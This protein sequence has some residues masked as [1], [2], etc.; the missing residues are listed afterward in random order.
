MVDDEWKERGT[1]DCRLL[2]QEKTLKICA[3]HIVMPDCEMEENVSSDRAWIWHAADFAEE[4]VKEETFA[5]K[6]KDAEIAKAFRA[7]WDK[8][9]E[10]NRA[11]L[12]AGAEASGGA[13]G[14]G[15]EAK[16]EEEDTVPEHAS[17]D[18]IYRDDEA[19]L[20]ASTARYAALA[21]AFEAKYGAKPAFFVRAPG[22]VNLIGEHIDYHNYP[23]CPMA[24]TQDIAIAVGAGEAHADA[25]GATVS[26]ANVVEKFA[27]GAFPADP[28]AKVDT[29]SHKWYHY[30]QCGYKGA[31]DAAPATKPVALQLMI[32]GNVPASAGVSSSSALVVASLLATAEAHGIKL[33]RHALADYSVK[34]ERHIGTMSGGMDQTISVFGE[35]GS[36]RL[37]EFNP[38]RVHPVPLP[39]DGVF[40]VANSLVEASKAVDPTAYY[41]LRVTEGKL[42]AK[43]VCKK[44]GAPGWEGMQTMLDLQTALGCSVPGELVEH[45]ERQLKDGAY[46]KEELAAEFGKPC[47]ELFEGDPKREGALNVLS[48]QDGFQLKRR[49]RHVASEAARVQSFCMAAGGGGDDLCAQ[50]GA[51]MDQ[52]QDSCRDDYECSCEALDE[53][54]AIAREGGASGARLTGAGWGGCAVILAPAAKVD[55][56][57]E[58]VRSKFFSSRE[59]TMEARGL[60]MAK[61]LFKSRPAPGAAIY[62]PSA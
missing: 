57:L 42:A 22:R 54:C 52:S 53:L 51:L 47:T 49:S 1:G 20:A 29:E 18:A 40:V 31:F 50:L 33:S 23:V 3:N 56:V 16:A 11:A 61:V 17:L 5:I 25:A 13:G 43:L 36:A 8:A 48:K 19:L 62:R 55:A 6:F 58:A 32:D 26:V 37:I 12:G 10:H 28:A 15:E 24:L 9:R 2:R 7:E 59:G 4:T 35:P 30:V 38:I 34:T 44:A 21:A 46:T 27:A 14:S 60:D 41:N 39:D 45:I